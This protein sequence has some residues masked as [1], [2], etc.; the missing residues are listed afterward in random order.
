MG[1]RNSDFPYLKSSLAEHISRYARYYD[2][3][4][5]YLPLEHD[6]GTILAAIDCPAKERI[7]NG[8]TLQSLRDHPEQRAAILVNGSFN[9]SLDVQGALRDLLPSLARTSRV[10]AVLYN[11]YLRLLYQLSNTLGIRSAPVPTM[12]DPSSLS[13]LFY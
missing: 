4:L 6:P 3:V 9:Y 2:A 12:L 5:Q 10:I 7:P 13:C 11:P 8:Q 1:T